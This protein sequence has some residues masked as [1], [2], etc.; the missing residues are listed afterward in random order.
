M[1][2]ERRRIGSVDGIKV[3]KDADD[4]LLF[5]DLDL[6]RS[7]LLG[8]HGGDGCLNNGDAEVDAAQIEIL[9]GLEDDGGRG[10]LCESVG[11]DGEAVWDRGTEVFEGEGSAVI[12]GDS[13]VVGG[14]GTIDGDGR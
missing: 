12:G 10:P 6:L 3:G 7:D 11:S 13:C 4:A 9:A 5:L 2:G 8:R 14:I 1:C